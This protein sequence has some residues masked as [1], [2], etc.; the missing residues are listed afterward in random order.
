MYIVFYIYTHYNYALPFPE[1]ILFRAKLTP[2][3]LLIFAVG[4]SHSVSATSPTGCRQ[5]FDNLKDYS[6]LAVRYC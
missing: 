3:V 2:S 6:D 1:M 5:A 4:S